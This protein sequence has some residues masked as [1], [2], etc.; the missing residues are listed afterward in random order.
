MSMDKWLADKKAIEERKRREEKYKSLSKEETLE[1]KK[2]KIRNLVQKDKKRKVKEKPPE[3]L[4][5]VIEFRDWLNNR[6][7]LRGD[8]GKIEVWIKNLYKSIRSSEKKRMESLSEKEKR[9]KVL[10][11]YKKVPPDFLDELTRIAINKKIKGMKRTNSDNYYLR[12]IKKQIQEKLIEINYY[13]ILKE[14]L[15]I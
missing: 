5:Q 13:E 8:I 14:V 15:E 2:E 1:L 10:E 11:E 3:F 4:S 9:K 7:Y 6:K 12:K